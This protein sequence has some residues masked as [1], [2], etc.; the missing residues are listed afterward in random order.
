MLLLIRFLAD[1]EDVQESVFIARAMPTKILLMLFYLPLAFPTFPASDAKYRKKSY[2]IL[3]RCRRLRI[4]CCHHPRVCLLAKLPNQ[5]Q[6]WHQLQ[7]QIT[8]VIRWPRHQQPQG[9]HEPPSLRRHP[10]R[11][12][13]LRN[14]PV[15]ILCLRPLILLLPAAIQRT[16]P[17][18]QFPKPNPSLPVRLRK[19]K[20]A[21]IWPCILHWRVLVAILLLLAKRRRLLLTRPSYANKRSRA[22]R[23][24]VLIST[25]RSYNTRT[26]FPLAAATRRTA[27]RKRTIKTRM[28]SRT[29]TILSWI[30]M[31]L[32]NS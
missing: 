10:S 8:A 3:L 27:T 16:A 15:L 28:A 29:S 30:T 20:L 21:N 25:T 11:L 17:Q 2:K 9:Q 19:D 12:R 26:V 24:I 23:E 31:S 18:P 14:E 1:A 22:I 7:H 32:S 6:R 4:G 5:R 13:L